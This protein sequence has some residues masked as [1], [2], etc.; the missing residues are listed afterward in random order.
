MKQ[1]LWRLRDFDIKSVNEMSSES[2]SGK[3]DLCL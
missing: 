1:E 2:V 3:T